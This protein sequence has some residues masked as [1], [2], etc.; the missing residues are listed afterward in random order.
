MRGSAPLSVYTGVPG[1]ETEPEQALLRQLARR[2]PAGGVYV[3]TGGEFGMSVSLVCQVADPTVRVVSVDLFP[4]DLLDIHRGNLKEAGF[5]D[6]SEQIAGD[7]A[8][9]GKAWDGGPID[10]LFIDDDH[11]YEGCKRSIAAWVK[12]V[13]KGGFVV[14]H[15]CACG[16]NKQPHVLHYEVT[17]AVSEWFMKTGG[18][19]KAL[20]SVGSAMA[21]ERVK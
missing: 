1:W 4:G 8:T 15:D 7:S 20:D 14:F 10:L 5:A 2:I 9:V 12:H 11:S 16:T 17:R 21:F 6:R 13:K 19:W 3:E 18:K